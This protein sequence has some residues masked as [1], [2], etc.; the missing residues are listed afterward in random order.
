LRDNELK[1]Y[2]WGPAKC[3]LHAFGWW[4]PLQTSPILGFADSG[5]DWIAE[6]DPLL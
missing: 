2:S 4:L 6:Y 3:G 5:A 1:E